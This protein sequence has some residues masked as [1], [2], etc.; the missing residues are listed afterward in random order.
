V[1]KQHNTLYYVLNSFGVGSRSAPSRA[2]NAPPRA[3]HL[4]ESRDK[5]FGA[6]VDA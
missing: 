5:R 1:A 4:L 6:P 2:A 3:E